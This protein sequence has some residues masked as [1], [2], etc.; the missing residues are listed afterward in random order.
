M[1]DNLVRVLTSNQEV[2]ALAVKSTEVVATAQELHQTSPVA[3]AALGRALTG[4]LLM[5]NMELSGS[6][7]SLTIRGS[8][9]LKKIIVN[10]NQDGEVRGYVNNPQVETEINEQG[11]LD[12]AGAIGAGELV[13]EKDLGL[14]DPYRGQIPLVS[15]EIAED[16]TYYFTNSEQIPSSVGLGVLVDKDLSVRA[17]GGFVIQVL[18]EAS[19]ETIDHLEKNIANLEEVSK[20]I[21]EGNGPQELL[22]KVLTGFD[23]EIIDEQDVKFKCKCDKDRIE[24]MILGLGEEELRETIEQEGQVE[25]RCQF[26]GKKYQFS[27]AEIEELL[28]EKAD[29]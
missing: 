3:T 19:D 8:G 7:I 11:K 16:L 9:Q 1:E 15:G 20:I 14:K 29:D 27:E 23:F 21:D 5:S 28:S 4:G 18:P 13:V 12:V 24:E 6:E 26:C 2:R 25:I 22:D 17:A 10:A